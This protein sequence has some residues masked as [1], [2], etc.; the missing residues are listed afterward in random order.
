MILPDVNV[1][2]YAMRAELP[3]Y[4]AY[5]PWLEA[6]LADAEP[7]ALSELVLS[8]V[9]RVTTH[10][11]IYRPPLHL[12]EA[13]SFADALRAQ[14]HAVVVRP[15]P[16]HWQHFTRLCEQA[17]AT[18]ELVADAYH[19]ALAIEHGCEWVTTDRDFARFPGL[20][21]RHPLDG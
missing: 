4:A 16:R 13:L 5:R 10:P 18:G 9:V 7:F 19:A 2:L 17:G 15:G 8:A 20:R 14:P 12:H 21:W 6:V 1:L 3:E 11:R